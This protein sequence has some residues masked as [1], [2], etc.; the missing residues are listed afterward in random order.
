MKTL[1][2]VDV[3]N[4]FVPGGSLAVPRGDEVVGFI[5]ML[6]PQYEQ[7]IYTQ[8]WH[9][10]GHSSFVEQGGPWPAHCV[11]DTKG[12]ELHSDLTV[13]INADVVQKGTDPAADSYSAFA[14]DNGVETGLAL[15]LRADGIKQ[16]DIVGLATEYCVKFTVLDALKL[17]FHPTVLLSGCRGISDADINAAIEEMEKAGAI[18]VAA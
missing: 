7:V 8:D 10:E 4:D 6:I 18:V 3:Q 2:V 14:D 1:I 11:Q 15:R 16:I 9:P 12:A 17:G 5:N 13:G